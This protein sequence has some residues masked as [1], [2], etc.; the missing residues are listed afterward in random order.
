VEIILF[1]ESPGPLQRL[2]ASLRA[3]GALVSRSA[4]GQVGIAI[5]VDP[6]HML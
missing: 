2:V 6:I 4:Q 1:A 5:D 3:R